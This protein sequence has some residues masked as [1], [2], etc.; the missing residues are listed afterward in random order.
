MKQKASPP[1]FLRV[2]FVIPERAMFVSVTIVTPLD[3][4]SIPFDVAFSVNSRFAP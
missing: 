1:S 4:I 2:G 3:M